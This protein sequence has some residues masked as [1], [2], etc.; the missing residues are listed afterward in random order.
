MAVPPAYDPVIDQHDTWLAVNPVQG[1]PKGCT[2]CSLN[3]LGL[4]GTTPPNSP[5]PPRHSTSSWPTGT[6]TRTWCWLSTPAPTPSPH[7][8]PAPT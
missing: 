1:C 7:P 4:T 6:T 5:P 2:Y 3:D 8:A